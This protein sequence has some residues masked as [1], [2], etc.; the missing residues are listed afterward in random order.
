MVISLYP[1]FLRMELMENLRYITFLSAADGLSAFPLPMDKKLHMQGL[2]S[3]RVRRSRCY[4]AA[5]AA[6]HNAADALFSHRP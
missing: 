6:E 4:A 3:C 5:K 1:F 2:R